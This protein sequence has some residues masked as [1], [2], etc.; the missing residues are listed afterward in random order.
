MSITNPKVARLAIAIA[1]ALGLFFIVFVFLNVFLVAWAVWRY[2]HHNSMVEPWAAV[3]SLAPAVIAAI[4]IAIPV[5]KRL[6]VRMQERTK[7]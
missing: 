2:P 1:L 6:T 4:L 7:G 5:S 3:V